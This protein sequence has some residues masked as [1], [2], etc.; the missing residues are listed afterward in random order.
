MKELEIKFRCDRLVAEL[1]CRK[2]NFVSLE[3]AVDFIYGHD[4]SNRH[5]HPFVPFKINELEEQKYGKTR[6]PIVTVETARSG[7]EKTD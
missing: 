2:S 5:K 4:P 3:I 6:V 7:L 1:A